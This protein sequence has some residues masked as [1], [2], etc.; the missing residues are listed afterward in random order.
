MK[1]DEKALDNIFMAHIIYANEN[2]DYQK[3]SE[4]MLGAIYQKMKSE[5][6]ED[7]FKK[8]AEKNNVK[9]E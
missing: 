1:D 8:I 7:L 3:D 5:N 9:I 2:S 6:K 4:Q